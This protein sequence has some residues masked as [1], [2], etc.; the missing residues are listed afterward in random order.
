MRQIV[1]DTETTGFSPQQGH[2]I[3]EIGCVEILNR[4]VTGQQ[5]HCYLQ[6]DREIDA[7]AQ[8]VHGLTL[9]FLK[10]KPRFT[11]I[12]QELIQFIQGAELIIHNAEFDVGFLNHELQRL[13]MGWGP[14]TNY[15]TVLDTLGLARRLHPGQK[16]D[17]DTLCKRYHIDNARR[18]FHGALLDAQLL[19]ETYLAMT[20]GQV[21]LL[22]HAQPSNSSPNSTQSPRVAQ[23][24]PPLPIL[25]P[26]AEELEAHQRYLA[27]LDKTTTGNCLWLTLES[28]LRP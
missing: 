26:T 10:D 5:F 8:Q 24:R 19:A 23:P 9:G 4:K 28:T 15:C 16:N 3:I 11:D 18:Q 13:K 21:S 14:L 6:P 12:V 1:L 17:L 22:T 7:G 27:K 20:G 2:R 25:L